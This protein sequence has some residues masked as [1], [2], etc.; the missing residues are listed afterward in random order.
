MRAEVAV[1]VVLLAA[2]VGFADPPRRIY[3]V[4][5]PMPGG[6]S[7]E[8]RALRE[9]FELQLREELKRRGATVL[10]RQDERVTA[11]VLRPRLEVLARGL[12]LELIG[13]RSNDKKLLGSISVTAGGS[14]REAQLKALVRHACF[15]ASQFDP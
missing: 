5:T 9:A 3:L 12:S 13:V 7:P 15:E 8:S 11:I 4:T 2:S 1:V 6:L 14:T 10:D